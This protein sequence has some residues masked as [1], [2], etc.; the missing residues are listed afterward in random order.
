MWSNTGQSQGLLPGRQ[1]VGPLA[2]M[3]LTPIAAVL[4]VRT[5]V[6]PA[7]DGSLSK[8]LTAVAADPWTE[9]A[10]SFVK[11]SQETL[12]FLV[13]FAAFQA[14]LQLYVPG[15]VFKGPVTPAGE[16][17][18]YRANGFQCFIITLV[19]WL[20]GTYYGFIPAT[21]IWDKH[22]E[23]TTA[24]C[25]FSFAFCTWLYYK[26]IY[27]PSSRDH[28]SQ[29][30]F[31]MDFYWGTELYPRIGD[32]DVKLFTNCRFGLILWALAPLSFAAQ[33]MKLND[34]HLSAAMIVNIALQLIY[35]AKV[36]RGMSGRRGGG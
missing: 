13:C 1:L 25:F 5:N 34:G 31:I 10:N 2:I 11:P 16:V 36:T 20:L 3:T 22:L 8:M 18:V 14:F 33:Q 27:F 23:I 12:L 7:W 15:R 29:G 35:L 32:W 17:P 21:I 6:D 19:T 28:S 24:M 4:F 26:G 9:I 30:N